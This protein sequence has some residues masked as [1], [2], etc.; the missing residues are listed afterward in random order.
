MEEELRREIEEICRILDEHGQNF[1]DIESK[2]FQ[3]QQILRAALN[4]TDD[5]IPFEPYY[6]R[7]TESDSRYNKIFNSRGEQ[8]HFCFIR[9][10]I[11]AD[12]PYD[13][14][15]R[16]LI[17]DRYNFHLKTHAYTMED[18]FQPVGSPKRKFAMLIEPRSSKPEFY[19][20]LLRRK[21]WIEREFDLVLTFDS[22]I[23]SNFSN[24][25]FVPFLARFTLTPDA[26]SYKLKTES[27]LMQEDFS[28]LRDYRFAI[29]IE[30]ELSP[31]YFSEKLTNCF[32]TQTIPIYLGA[33]EIGRFFNTDGIIQI[34]AA[35]LDRIEKILS[36]CTIEEYNR[37]LPAILDNFQ[38]AEKFQSPMDSIFQTYLRKFFEEA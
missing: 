27:T 32:A 31:C 34:Q 20:E 29:V 15:G 19:D 18:I 24:A 17:W 26:D 36:Q 30:D 38:R 28:K 12:R 23:L 2:M 35:D 11:F 6:N 16:F 22:Q 21:D 9:D 13:G 4:L 3:E 7:F 33:T 14:A 1:L 37:R 8:M 5:K 25:R 10:K